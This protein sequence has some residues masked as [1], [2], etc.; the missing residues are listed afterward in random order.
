MCGRWVERAGAHH[1]CAGR[2]RRHCRSREVHTLEVKLDARG[3]GRKALRQ[4][5]EHD[6]E[7][8]RGMS[9]SDMLCA[10]KPAFVIKLNDLGGVTVLRMTEDNE[11]H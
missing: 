3:G 7:E 9:D 10:F 5:W 8:R 2:L 11:Y 6:D 1:C 4:Y